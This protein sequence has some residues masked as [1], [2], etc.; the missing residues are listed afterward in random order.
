MPSAVR[1]EMIAEDG[2]RARGPVSQPLT[3]FF[4][5]SSFFII[6]SFSFFSSL[7][8]NRNNVEQKFLK[9]AQTR[10]AAHFPSHLGLLKTFQGPVVN[11]GKEHL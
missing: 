2:T 10:C 7:K 11:C 9:N 4:F 8:E 3:R 6:L 1:E 5:L